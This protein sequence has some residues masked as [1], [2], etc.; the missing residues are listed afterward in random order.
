MRPAPTIIVGGLLLLAAA[1]A[2]GGR[3]TGI[4]MG[5][6][7]SVLMLDRLTGATWVCWD[8]DCRPSRQNWWGD[9]E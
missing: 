3:Y 8:E 9:R 1:F 6:P 7:G 2:L 4:P 5:R